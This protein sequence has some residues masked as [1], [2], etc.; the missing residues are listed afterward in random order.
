[1]KLEGLAKP[2]HEKDVS[3][4][5]EGIYDETETQTQDIRRNGC[6]KPDAKEAG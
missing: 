2:P 3:K 5:W 1:M 4:E 6:P